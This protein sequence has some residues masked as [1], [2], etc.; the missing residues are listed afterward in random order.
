VTLLVF[1]G[2][3]QLE[4]CDTFN[5]VAHFT[6]CTGKKTKIFDRFLWPERVKIS[7]IYGRV[8]VQWVERFKGGRT[9]VADDAR[10]G[11]PSTV[12][13]VQVK[14]Q[15]DQRIRDNRRISIN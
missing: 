1:I 4:Y 9:S 10:S 13:C 6:E 5:M 12:T 11:R 15:V 2:F 8:T 14:E 7:E 3:W